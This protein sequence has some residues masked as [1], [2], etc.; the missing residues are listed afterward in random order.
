M[1]E[2]RVRRVRVCS[3]ANIEGACSILW[4]WIRNTTVVWGI[5]KPLEDRA[6]KIWADARALH[7][8][9][10]EGGDVQTQQFATEEDLAATG[11]ASVRNLASAVND[12][13]AAFDVLHMVHLL[14]EGPAGSF[15]VK[16]EDLLEVFRDQ[17]LDAL[18]QY[19]DEH[20]DDRNVI[21]G[22]LRRYKVR[23]E[24][25]RKQ[26]LRSIAKDGIEK[27]D[28]ERALAVDLYEYLH[29]QGIEFLAEPKTGAG[30]PDL[31]AHR[32][33]ARELLAD[34]KY[35][36]PDDTPSKIKAVLFEGLRQVLDYCKE[37]SRAIG[38]LI[39]FSEADRILEFK[40]M[41]I[42]DV[43]PCVRIDGTTIYY[44]MID[45]ADIRSASKRGRAEKIVI[46]VAEAITTSIE[47]TTPS[48][49]EE[50]HDV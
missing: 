2:A 39:V 36:R 42:D 46:D 25:F 12:S 48:T 18:A 3:L 16:E 4:N 44:L 30:E 21:L 1:L 41:H 32:S 49:P 40:T 24:R 20:L 8:L 5:V 22:I 19:I 6:D 23:C 11:L 34:A 17:A 38:Y 47:S 7:T 37:E 15:H 26:R 29:D 28:G 13:Q 43:F 31:V 35:L 50:A 9:A 45:I 27:L 14:F 33:A 10:E